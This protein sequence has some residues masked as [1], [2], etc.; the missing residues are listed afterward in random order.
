[1]SNSPFMREQLMS[2][3]LHS[4]LGGGATRPRP[5][6]VKELWAYIKKHN[7]QDPQ[8]K[9]DIICDAPLKNVFGKGRVNMF[10]M[11][12]LLSDHLRPVE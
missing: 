2:N 6:V 3:E 10:E 1:M 5:H 4:V 9:R 11:Q 12:K 8:S 7:L